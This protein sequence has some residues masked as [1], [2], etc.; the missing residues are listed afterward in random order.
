M[1]HEIRRWLQKHPHPASLRCEL[2]DGETKVI[3]LGVSRSKWRDAE[4][5]IPDDAVSVEALDNAGDTLRVMNFELEGGGEQQAKTQRMSELG[6]LA[7]IITQSNRD[8][9]EMH[10]KAFAQGH[11]VQV[12]MLRLMSDRLTGL[13]RAWHKLLMS[14][15]P[16]GEG[17]MVENLLAGVVQAEL[18]NG[19]ARAKGNG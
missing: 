10:A 4:S 18:S 12:Q 3:K 16:A 9:V 13:E 11:E 5:A 1:A 19:A 8:A 17:G 14:Q 15:E 2:A 6:E 7:R